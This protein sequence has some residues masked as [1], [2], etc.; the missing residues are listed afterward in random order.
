MI[1][2]GLQH[3]ITYSLLNSMTII[4]STEFTLSF[5]KINGY[6]VTMAALGSWEKGYLLC[7]VRYPALCTFPILF[8]ASTL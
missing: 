1:M 3:K 2:Y 7:T 4:I 5:T 8:A 6:D